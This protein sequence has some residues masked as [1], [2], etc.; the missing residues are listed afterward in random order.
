MKEVEDGIGVACL[1]A[2]VYVLLSLSLSI[3]WLIAAAFAKA[4]A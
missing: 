4:F 1:L 2:A 3:L